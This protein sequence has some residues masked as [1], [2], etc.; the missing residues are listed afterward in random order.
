MKKFIVL[1][2]GMVVLCGV[3]RAEENGVASSSILDK[4]CDNLLALSNERK[5]SIR[6]N[7]AKSTEEQQSL[8]VIAEELKLIRGLERAGAYE[9]NPKRCLVVKV[10]GGYYYDDIDGYGE[11]Y[12][13]NDFVR[14]SDTGN[15]GKKFQAL[16]V[17]A[18]QE[19]TRNLQTMIA[20]HKQ[21]F[22]K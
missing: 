10:S 13:E 18:A 19:K 4:E 7:V 14:L 11:C 16:I 15:I 20:M 2:M 12:R 9:L 1:T 21:K 5:S 8:A 3:V 6:D 22:P 17:E